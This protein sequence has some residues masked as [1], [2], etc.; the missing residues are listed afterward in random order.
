MLVLLLLFYCFSFNNIL[1]VSRFWFFSLFRRDFRLRA[2]CLVLRH[3]S[4][5]Y[6][7]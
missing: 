3:V 2:N 6:A 7:L 5:V 1:F 4:F